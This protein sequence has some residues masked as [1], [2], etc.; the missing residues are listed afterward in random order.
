MNP[1]TANQT[2]RPSS[3]T[4]AASPTGRAGIIASGLRARYK[5]LLL[6]VFCG[7]GL[8]VAW[9]AH[10]ADDHVHLGDH[11]AGVSCLSRELFDVHC[12][13]CGMTRS[14]VAFFDGDLIGSLT[15]H[16]GGFLIALTLLASC[17]AV[18]TAAVMGRRPVSSSRRYWRA[19]EIIAVVCLLAGLKNLV[20]PTSP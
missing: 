2:T 17:I 11:T 9:L 15:Y 20:V 3:S 6:A 5:D 13:Y 14:V 19:I 12:P 4:S 16:P 10:V 8:V 7:V 1:Q 18:V